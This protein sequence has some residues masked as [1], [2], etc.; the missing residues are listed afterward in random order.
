M[1]VCAGPAV[2]AVALVPGRPG[3]ARVRLCSRRGA[4][5]VIAALEEAGFVVDPRSVRHVDTGP[6]PTLTV[7]R[8]GRGGHV[9]ECEVCDDLLVAGAVF[10]G[11]DAA[12]QAAGAH[13][14][15]FHGGQLTAAPALAAP[16]PPRGGRL[17]R[18]GRGRGSG[19]VENTFWVGLARHLRGRA[20]GRVLRG[21]GRDSR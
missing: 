15:T 1:R 11:V 6:E 16:P 13:D 18:G 14:D 2:T 19:K 20:A 10:N 3:V 5:A 17:P 7:A 9:V 21:A 12:A 8:P 4:D